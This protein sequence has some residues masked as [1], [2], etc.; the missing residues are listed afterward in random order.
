[1]PNKGSDQA[2]TRKEHNYSAIAKRTQ[3][4]DPFGGVVSDGGNYAM[5]IDEASATVTYVGIAQI[6]TATSASSW[7]VKRIS[8]S[9][10]V[11]TITWADGDDEF[12][13]I[14]D[15]RASLSYS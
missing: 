3:L 2:V 4:V 15:N 13:N 12:D 8:V 14:W 7:Q 10:N 9:G 6:G 11:T 1:M 5:V